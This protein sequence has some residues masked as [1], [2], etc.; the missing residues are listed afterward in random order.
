M[1]A[2]LPWFRELAGYAG[3]SER[4]QIDVAFHQIAANGRFNEASGRLTTIGIIAS[5]LQVLV[6]AVALWIAI[7]VKM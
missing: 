4:I 6:A 7:R 5:I 3:F 1:R 2:L